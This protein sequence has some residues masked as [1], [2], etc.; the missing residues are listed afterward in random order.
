M[1]STMPTWLLPLVGV[2]SAVLLAVFGYVVSLARDVSKLQAV[3]E[4]LVCIPTLKLKVEVL[5]TRMETYMKILDPHL[6][7]VLRDWPTH[8]ERDLLMDKLAHESLNLTEV[9]RLDI[10]LRE[11]MQETA[12]HEKQLGIGLAR[13]RLSWLKSK[14]ESER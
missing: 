10:L 12:S 9:N 14:L 4:S 6:A 3:C 2:I 5:E 1:T 8:I 11:A 7:K 13:A